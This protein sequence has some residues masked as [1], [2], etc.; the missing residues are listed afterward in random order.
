[1]AVAQIAIAQIPQYVVQDP[2]GISARQGKV[3]YDFA[4]F[5]GDQQLDMIVSTTSVTGSGNMIGKLYIKFFSGDYSIYN[6]IFQNPDFT[7]NLPGIS[8]S[9]NISVSDLDNDGDQDILLIKPVGL[10]ADLVVE[11][12]ENGSAASPSFSIV[13][14]PD[15]APPFQRGYSS[16][17]DHNNDGLDDIVVSDIFGKVSF[18]SNNANL[19]FSPI[20]TPS[21]LT[22]LRSESTYATV[23]ID[24]DD[25]EDHIIFNLDSGFQ[26][27][28]G[29]NM[30]IDTHGIS[31]FIDPGALTNYNYDMHIFDFNANG[32]EDLLLSAFTAQ[33]GS[34]FVTKLFLITDIQQCEKVLILTS[35]DDMLS[36]TYKAGEEIILQDTLNILPAANLRLS[37]DVISM[38]G[39]LNVQNTNT[40]QIDDLGCNGRF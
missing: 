10:G 5:N 3:Y 13:S 12:L 18:Y 22:N 19:D 6:Q 20:A 14:T 33:A 27:L 23:D 31:T 34:G 21:G 32:N 29:A 17:I 37:A 2:W 30:E 40:V 11:I 1:M 26:K 35:L 9:A 39:L 4:D 25:I 15:I 38:Q 36:N 8:E 28:I 24:N 7:Y 16:I